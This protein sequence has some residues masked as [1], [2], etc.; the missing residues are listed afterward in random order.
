MFIIRHRSRTDTLKKIPTYVQD[1]GGINPRRAFLKSPDSVQAV[2]GRLTL[3]AS[4]GGADVPGAHVPQRRGLAASVRA[5]PAA[6]AAAR[7]ARRAPPRACARAARAAPRAPRR[8]GA[9]GAARARARAGARAGEGEVRLL[10]SILLNVDEK[11]GP[12]S[13]SYR[14]PADRTFSPFQRTRAR[15]RT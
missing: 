10:T 4:G 14:T 5:V 7:A 8:Q 2:T 13:R 15:A 3:Q 6:G 12:S 9:R 1:Y 11:G